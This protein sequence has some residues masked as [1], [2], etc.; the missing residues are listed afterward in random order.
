M[1]S[2]NR[3]RHLYM[4][5][6]FYMDLICSR[7]CLKAGY[8]I[9]RSFF[10]GKHI[11]HLSSWY[12]N[13]H[14]LFFKFLNTLWCDLSIIENSGNTM[15]MKFLFS[16]FILAELSLKFWCSNH[17]ILY[18]YL[19]CQYFTSFCSYKCVMI[20]YSNRKTITWITRYSEFKLLHLSS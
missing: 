1:Y 13:S 8:C 20:H 17:L 2:C 7:R 14:G 5:L 11:L 18:W 12:S 3:L 4:M 19:L 9:K 15:K 6:H 16:Y 10:S